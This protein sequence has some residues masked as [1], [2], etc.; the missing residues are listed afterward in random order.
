MEAQVHTAPL[1]L[2]LPSISQRSQRTACSHQA[3][4]TVMLALNTLSQ[5]VVLETELFAFITVAEAPLKLHFI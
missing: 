4:H 1:F 2:F 5:K 3:S